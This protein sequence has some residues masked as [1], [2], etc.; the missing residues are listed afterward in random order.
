[1]GG[2][3][4]GLSRCQTPRIRRQFHAP[5]LAQTSGRNPLHER[6]LDASVTILRLKAA[7]FRESPAGGA[8][9]VVSGS[10]DCRRARPQTG[11][12]GRG[13]LDVHERAVARAKQES[14]VDQRAQ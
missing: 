6:A 12:D 2:G 4:T 8:Y 7:R 3:G 1:M 10:R 13:L 9:I 11:L 5:S 14:R